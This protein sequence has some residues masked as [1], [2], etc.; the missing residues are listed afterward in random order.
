MSRNAVHSPVK[1]SI[2]GEED[3]RNKFFCGIIV[4]VKRFFSV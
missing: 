3:S 2:T 4:E 1:R